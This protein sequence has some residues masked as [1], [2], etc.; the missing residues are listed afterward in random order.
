MAF[1]FWG[2]MRLRI[3]SCAHRSYWRRPRLPLLS[4]ASI[5]IASVLLAPACAVDQPQAPGSA[6]PKVVTTL[7]LFADLVLQIGGDRMEV[8]AL[9]PSGADPHTFDPSPRDIERIRA[10]D[11]VIVNGLGLETAALRVMERNLRKGTPLVKLAEETLAAGARS[12]KGNPHFWLDINNAREY[13]RIIR[14]ALTEADP[15]GRQEYEANYQRFLAQ[16]DGLD[17][18][19]RDRVSSVPPERR[20]LVTTHAAFPYLAQYLGLQEVA[21]VAP[22]PG[23]EPSLQDIAELE[24]AIRAERVPAVFIEPQLGAESRVLKRAAADAGVKVCTLYADTL[25]DKVQSYVEMMRFNADEIARCL[26]G[27]GG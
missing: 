15:E 18:Y 9:L 24:R 23:Q 25:D 16:L 1:L 13:A 6:P 20:K 10:A 19:V 27:S 17:R 14:D 8:F 5:G 7:P 26:G 21:V 11:V 4:A 12:L 3:E 2:H 22:S